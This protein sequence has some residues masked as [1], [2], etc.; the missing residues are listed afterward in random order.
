MTDMTDLGDDFSGPEEDGEDIIELT[1][2]VTE[3]SGAEDDDEIIDLTDVVETAEPEPASELTPELEMDPEPEGEA[4]LELE[5]AFED[6]SEDDSDAELELD[7]PDFGEEPD[8]EP[9]EPVLDEDE[10]GFDSPEPDI[11]SGTVAAPVAAMTEISADDIE[12]A[13]ER[14]IEKKFNDRF[15]EM[16]EEAMGRVIEQQINEVKERLKQALNLK[17]NA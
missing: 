8:P 6:E 17:E 16:V 14:V 5:P 13:L 3:E 15:G 10:L 12:A 1:D 11:E 4:G 9:A 7:M 2:I